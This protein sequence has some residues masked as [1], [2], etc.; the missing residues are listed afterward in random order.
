ME[1]LR[2][3]VSTQP[4]FGQIKERAHP[5]AFLLS[6]E[7]SPGDPKNLPAKH[8]ALVPLGIYPHPVDLAG[9]IL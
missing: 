5:L 1:P 6:V 4:E 9:Q 8:D 3:T 7:P 2:V